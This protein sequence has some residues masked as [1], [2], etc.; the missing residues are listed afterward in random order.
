MDPVIEQ[1]FG[2]DSVFS[3]SFKG[4]EPRPGQMLIADTVLKAFKE[5]KHALAE[6]PC[7]TGKTVAYIVPAAW[8]IANGHLVEQE[9]EARKRVND[10]KPRY[11]LAATI[12]FDE[13]DSDNHGSGIREF[14]G[15]TIP[16][17]FRVS[18]NYCEHCKTT[19]MRSQ[20]A[21]V[22]DTLVRKY[23]QVGGS[24]V[25]AMV[26]RSLRALVNDAREN[27]KTEKEEKERRRIRIVIATANIA[28]QEQLVNKDLP[29]MAEVLPWKFD[30]ALL[31]GVNNY[32]CNYKMQKGGL[33][34]NILHNQDLLS[35]FTHIQ[36]WAENTETGD[37][38]ELPFVPNHVVWN[39][40]STTSDECMK[41]DCP[42]Y[43]GCFVAAAKQ[44]ARTVDIIVTNYHML[45]AYMSLK[46]VIENPDM[47]L[48]KIDYLILDEAHE[49]AEIARDFFGVSVN[50]NAV[51]AIS[52]SVKSMLEDKKLAENLSA[53][54]EAFFTTVAAFAKSSLYNIRL[55]TPKFIDC[56]GIVEL[57][58][59]VRAK[60]TARAEGE[61][62]KKLRKDFEKLASRADNASS[63]IQECVLQEKENSAYWIE[64][65]EKNVFLKG[66]PIFAH[67]ILR[68]C[69]YNDS[70]IKST[71]A[72]SATM[73]TGDPHSPKAF[74]FIKGEIGAP[75]DVLTVVG[76]SP[77]DFSKQSLVIVPGGM[78]DPKNAQYTDFVAFFT[79][80]V[81][82]SCN[83]RTLG[84]FTSYKNLNAVYNAVKNCGHRVMK[85]GEL[86][87]PELTRIFREDVHSVLLGT[88]SFW[89][90]VD[91]PG[92][93]LT[94]L[95]IDRLP[96]VPP[97]DP[98]ADAITSKMQ[99]AFVKYHVPK[100]AITFRQGVGRLIRTKTD[101]GVV[102]ILDT[103]VVSTNWGKAFFWSS[104]PKGMHARQDLNVI[105]QFLEWAKSQMGAKS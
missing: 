75:D 56:D 86:P 28:L 23:L 94:G 22:F 21:V 33:S 91:V 31:K 9:R 100:T 79:R 98:I 41:S 87:R 43:E 19:R 67:D 84:L 85:Q 45:F 26:G 38:S 53:E 97:T 47:P 5:S 83:G 37:M 49:A 71:V 27:G 34:N 82:E 102:V 90:G 57:L 73:T 70:T 32:V 50:R 69:L 29:A 62:D 48:T 14:N 77:F 1:V 76:D 59:K 36:S 6:G 13:A 55:K 52:H 95:V 35:E 15:H 10:T 18:K 81:I 8:M 60:A 17:E 25:E 54:S 40:C 44:R 16:D 88:D 61:M 63:V 103:R 2:P 78:P 30:F 104:L 4:Y 7:G 92:E 66:A 68:S 20:G 3:K 101:I 64:E 105:P 11:E 24:C 96:F 99:N 46:G 51:T 39:R 58:D 72:I 42:A 80:K 89:T 93:S 65:T 12:D 74:D